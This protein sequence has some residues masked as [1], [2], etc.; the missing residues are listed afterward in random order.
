MLS[1]AQRTA[2][3]PE[4]GTI[5]IEELPMGEVGFRDLAAHFAAYPGFALLDSRTRDGGLGRFSLL[6]FAPFARL[7]TRGQRI[8]HETRKG[9]RA[10][11]GDP[12]AAL[13]ERLARH[14]VEPAAE[15]PVPFVGGAIGYLSYETGRLLETLPARASDVWHLPD[16]CFG[17]YDFALVQSHDDGRVF[18]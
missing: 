5:R 17:F 1:L 18:F 10:L 4:T 12:F 14:R 15:L 16:L 9:R 6:S 3:V 2:T 8:V 11:R 7:R 13:A